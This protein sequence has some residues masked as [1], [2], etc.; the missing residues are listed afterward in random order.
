MPFHM[1]FSSSL[2]Y[3]SCKGIFLNISTDPRKLSSME[4]QEHHS[5]YISYFSTKNSKWQCDVKIPLMTGGKQALMLTEPESCN[6]KSFQSLIQI[7]RSL[8]LATAN[9][10]HVH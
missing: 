6:I 8:Q 5:I 3:H 9:D 2:N 1:P 7:K 10:C 4:D